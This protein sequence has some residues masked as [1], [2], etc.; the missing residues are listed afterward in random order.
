MQFRSSE[1]LDC[2]F[3]QIPCLT[4]SE[5]ELSGV[6]QAIYDAIKHVIIEFVIFHNNILHF[7]GKLSPA[8][9]LD[10]VSGA[11]LQMQRELQWFKVILDILH[12]I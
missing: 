3:E 2:I 10:C 12:S 8:S 5:L 1:V 6:N 7:A 11:A 4:I 9:Q